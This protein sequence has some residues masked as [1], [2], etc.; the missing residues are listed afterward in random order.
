MQLPIKPTLSSAGYPFSSASALSWERGR[1]R[2]GE[3]GPTTYG[4]R[5]SR[6]ISITS[7]KGPGFAKTSG[8]G[9]QLLSV[10]CG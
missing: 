6:S 3:N 2:S 7:S 8:I 10:A 9:G 5:V 4:V 1:A